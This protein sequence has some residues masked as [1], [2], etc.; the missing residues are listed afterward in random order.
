MRLKH[1]NISDLNFDLICDD[2][3]TIIKND[4]NFY[5]LIFLDAFT[6]SKCPCLWSYEFFRLL[7]EHLN[8]NG[9]I[10]TYSTSAAVR[11]GMVEAGFH[12]G[13]TLDKKNNK[14]IGTIATRN[15]DLIKSPLAEFDLGLLKTKAGIFYRD[16]NLTGQNEA[17][18]NLRKIEVENSK[19]MS[20]SQYK[21]Q[22]KV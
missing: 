2:A 17:I 19:K 9:M 4:T 11:N 10:L 18:N 22:H 16:K 1:F 12:I 5:D 14:I 3:R 7:Y 21:K 20:S 15:K 6:P 8:D 13:N